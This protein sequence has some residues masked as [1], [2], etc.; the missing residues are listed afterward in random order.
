MYVQNLAAIGSDGTAGRKG[1]IIRLLEQHIKRPMHWLVCLFH[2]NELQLRHLFEYINGSTTG[3]RSYTGPMG[4][5]LQ[6][7]DKMPLAEFQKMECD[8][9]RLP[10]NA[11]SDHSTDQL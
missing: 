4:T 10:D 3:P 9:S 6:L 2:S 11:V 8:L 7:R 5:L 1:G